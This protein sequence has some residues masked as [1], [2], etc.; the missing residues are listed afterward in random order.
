MKKITRLS[1]L[2]KRSKNLIVGVT[3]FEP[4]TT[5]SQTRHSTGLS[6]A[7]ET[8][9]N[10]RLFFHSAKFIFAV[11]ALII[12]CTPAFSTNR[13]KLHY[14]KPAHFFEEALPIGNGKI[15]AMVYGRPD[16]DRLSLNDITLWTGEPDTISYSDRSS[17]LA[18]V[19]KLLDDGKYIEADRAQKALQ[20]H[21]SENY[22]P[23]GD[24]LIKFDLSGNTGNYRRELD[25]S[26][27]LASTSFTSG[28]HSYHR[29]YF[30]SSPDSAIVVLLSTDNP[31]GM[32]FEVE[33]NS[34]LPHTTVAV[35]NGI[36]ATGYTAYKSYPHYYG[37][38][39]DSQ[40]FMY[41]PERGTRFATE[42]RVKTPDGTV[43]S[44]NNV[45]SVKGARTAT[46]VLS[47][48]TSFNGFD[49]NPS[50]H[51]KDYRTIA[52]SDIASAS[53]KDDNA[54][55]LNHMQDSGN[56]FGS[57]LRGV[58]GFCNRLRKVRARARLRHGMAHPAP[59]VA[60]RPDFH[61][62]EPHP[63][64][65]G[66]RGVQ[67]GRGGG[68]RVHRHHQLF[69]HGTDPAGVGVCGG[70]DGGPGVHHRPV[71]PLFP[72][73]EAADA[74]EEPRLRGGMAEHAH[75]F[76]HGPYSHENQT[77]EANRGPCGEHPHLGGHRRELQRY[78]QL[79][80]LRADTP[81]GG[82]QRKTLKH[83]IS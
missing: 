57:A 21:Y 11:S 49:K 53:S 2:I 59:H 81:D 45:I 36:E 22:Q 62:S 12:S 83:R 32:N 6:Y 64:L 7:P 74:G 52:A 29:T 77:H 20:G 9:A 69:H 39:P 5:W 43:N 30:A 44:N 61:Q 35:A 55:L 56:L 19:R 8:D 16:C 48:E 47:N 67:G 24:M 10:L 17:A 46:I 63:Q 80:R 27:A 34:Q 54:L 3:G 65:R 4:A 40:K 51:G 15:G 18:N 76:V 33:F 58:R 26:T 50:T 42:I 1:K 13:L 75:Q 23:L 66:E 73:G 28:P 37:D 79:C 68:A 70:G 60:D 82:K 31:E 72:G 71:R 25:L 38:V 14:N 78:D 41:D